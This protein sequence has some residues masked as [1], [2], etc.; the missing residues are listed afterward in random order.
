[1]RKTPEK[2]VTDTGFSV[3]VI[4]NV[5]I[6]VSGRVGYTAWTI[7]PNILPTSF[8]RVPTHLEN[9]ENEKINF[10]A[11]KCPGKNPGNSSEV[12]MKL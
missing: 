7:S 6:V 1:M 9:L 10:Q 11:R 2:Y 3:I 4:P 5:R 12:H 8:D